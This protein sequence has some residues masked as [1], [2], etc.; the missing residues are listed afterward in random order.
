MQKRRSRETESIFFQQKKKNRARKLSIEF[1]LVK[2]RVSC[3][4]SQEYECSGSRMNQAGPIARTV[5]ARG[6]GST[7]IF[8]EERESGYGEAQENNIWWQKRT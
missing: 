3:D 1:T 6:S 2:L 4:F 5:Y 7:L 8:D